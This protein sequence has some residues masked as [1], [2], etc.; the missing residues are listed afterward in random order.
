[1]MPGF[2]Y[3]CFGGYGASGGWGLILNAAFGILI[4]AGIVWLTIWAIR[5]F[6]A[7]NS[8]SSN[9]YPASPA[10][11]AKEVAQMRYARGEI[12]RDQYQQLLNDISR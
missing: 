2:G 3:G 6:S 9:L 4:F 11:S 7:R 10:S 8:D 5:R 1:M 12:T